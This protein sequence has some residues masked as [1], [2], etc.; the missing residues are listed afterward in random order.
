MKEFYVLR[1]VKDTTVKFDK[2]ELYGQDRS[3]CSLFNQL[4]IDSVRFFLH[5]L[6]LKVKEV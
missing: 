6:S 2:L 4:Q 1:D 5:T 3:K